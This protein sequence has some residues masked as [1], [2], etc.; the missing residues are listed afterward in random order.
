MPQSFTIGGQAYTLRPRSLN[1]DLEL[2]TDDGPRAAL[3]DLR[4]EAFR[5]QLLRESAQGRVI[6]L[7]RTGDAPDTA[8]ID[9]LLAEIKGYDAEVEAI[10][11]RET[12]AM[13]RFVGVVLR[14]T[15]DNP[16]PVDVLRDADI[17]D[18]TR[19]LD[20]VSGIPPTE[21]AE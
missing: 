6:S 4:M 14:D 21:A 11:L 17:D 1:L 2:G 13:I 19:V 5:V 7:A 9:T 12:E 20:A 18:L 16:P 8:A 3:R 15:D 10:D